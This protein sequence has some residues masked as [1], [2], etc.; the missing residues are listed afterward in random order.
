MHGDESFY[1]RSALACYCIRDVM[2]MVYRVSIDRQLC[3]ACR[4]APDLCPDLFVLGADNGKNRLVEAYSRETSNDV[5]TGVIPDERYACARKAA[6]V[7]PVQAIT[8]DAT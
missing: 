7:C 1:V 2:N 6:A 8:V 3:I 4:V 5:S